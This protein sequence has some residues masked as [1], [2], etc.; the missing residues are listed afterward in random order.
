M[1]FSVRSSDIQAQSISDV[2][3]IPKGKKK[4]RHKKEE[5]KMPN[6]M[7]ALE[8][9]FSETALQ[10]SR[11]KPTVKAGG[12]SE[13]RVK[14]SQ[15]TEGLVEFFC[16]TFGLEAFTEFVVPFEIKK[17]Q[18]FWVGDYHF[19]GPSEM[20]R[21]KLTT[22]ASNGQ[23]A[24][25]HEGL[26][27]G[28]S[29]IDKYLKKYLDCS[30]TGF[31]YGLEDPIYLVLES[32][33]SCIDFA[34]KDPQILIRNVVPNIFLQLS[35]CALGKQ[36]W[37]KVIQIKGSEGEEYIKLAFT[38]LMKSFNTEPEKNHNGILDA[39]SVGSIRD[40]KATSDLFAKLA[41][42]GL[43]I[44]KVEKKVVDVI[45]DLLSHRNDRARFKNFC[46]T[47]LASMRDASLAKN[48]LSVLP[49]LPPDMPAVILMG[50]DHKESYLSL[51]KPHMDGISGPGTK[52]SESDSKKKD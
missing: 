25:F 42:S 5:K 33:N 12:P 15:Y 34:N 32:V 10:A 13:D 40:Y 30:K 45:K 22:D 3:A 44:L 8:K 7:N 17:R 51:L 18:C 38:S 29:N 2:Q 19:V 39:F 41:L 37:R 27:A 49:K 20:L 47:T 48:F 36:I 46:N 23:C 21:K 14:Y 16:K 9:S 4:K 6:P 43:N 11:V 28:N 26:V 31:N 50:N 24:Y 35:G 52:K 1:D